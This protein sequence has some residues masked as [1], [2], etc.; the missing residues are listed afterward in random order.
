MEIIREDE[1]RKKAKSGLSGAYLFFGDEDYLKAHAIKVAEST[2][3]SDPSFAVFNYMKLDATAYSAD[4]LID[5]LTPLPMMADKKLVTIDGLNFSALKQREVDEL[6]TALENFSE[7]DYNVLIISVPSDMLDVGN[8]P[9]RPSQ[10]LE[11]L[12]KVITPV[13]FEKISG[14]KLCAWVEKHFASGGVKASREV[15]RELIEY[16]GKS[17][18]TL[19]SETE[20]ISCYLLSH[21][22]DTV[23]RDDVYEIANPE[24]SAEAFEL[25][26]ALTDGRYADALKALSVEKFRRTDPVILMGEV[27]KT[28]CELMTVKVLLESGYS[29]KEISTSINMNEYKAR[30]ICTS[31]AAKSKKKIEKALLLCS[32]ADL[33]LKTSA[34]DYQAIERLICSL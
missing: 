4:A 34:K 27:S 14:E 17:M 31:A 1:F 10:L 13:H 33:A 16:S 8:L 30:R 21:G 19:S 7:Y 12:R 2:V 3:C 23:T 32:E 5:A 25:A 6:I 24:I 18:F 26:N 20:K 15:C 22:R 11:R 29:A 9:K 28:I